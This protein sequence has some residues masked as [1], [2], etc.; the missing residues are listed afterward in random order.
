MQKH[1]VMNLVRN[2]QHDMIKE[3]RRIEQ[4]IKHLESY[5]ECLQNEISRCTTLIEELDKLSNT[6]NEA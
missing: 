6:S 1:I 3:G 5:H 2:Y 4:E